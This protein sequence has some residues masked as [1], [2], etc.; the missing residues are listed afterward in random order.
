MRAF[1]SLILVFALATAGSAGAADLAGTWLRASGQARITFAPCP[2]GICG[3]VTWLKPGADHKVHVGDRIFYAMVRTGPNRWAGKAY[4]PRENKT[5]SGE[6]TLENG[7]LISKTCM[8]AGRVCKSE[9][10]TR[11]S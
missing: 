3:R 8:L 10:L 5:Y 2:D 11:V 4:S 1:A 7:K 6:L 9:V